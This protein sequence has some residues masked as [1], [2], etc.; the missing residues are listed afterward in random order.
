MVVAQAPSAPVFVETAPVALT[1]TVG[2]SLTRTFT[3]TG[4]PTPAVGVVDRAQLPPG[5]TF[6]DDPD[7]DA[8][9]LSGKATAAGK[10][11]F[12]VSATNGAAPTQP[13]K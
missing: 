13:C 4:T 11:D 10:F 3:A 8:P 12:M 7:T 5:M 9:I 2:T 1:G 6:T